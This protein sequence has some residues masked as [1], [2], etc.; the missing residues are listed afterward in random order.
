MDTH[1]AYMK[2]REPVKSNQKG[3]SLITCKL[4]IR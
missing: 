1:K 3:T 2:L 4:V